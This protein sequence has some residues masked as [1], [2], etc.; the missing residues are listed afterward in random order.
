MFPLVV[1]FS[2]ALGSEPLD[3]GSPELPSSPDIDAR[4][5]A[6]GTVAGPGQ[7]EGVVGII[8]RSSEDSAQIGCSGSLIHPSWVLTAAHC[9]EHDRM[10]QAVL[11]GETLAI[12]W[13]E[14]L[15]DLSWNLSAHDWVDVK[16]VIRHPNYDW[17]AVPLLNDIALLELDSPQTG[18]AL[19]ALNDTNIDNRVGDDLRHVGYGLTGT[20]NQMG[21][22]R[23]KFQ[24]ITQVDPTIVRSASNLQDEGICKGDS[25]GPGLLWVGPGYVATTIISYG[26]EPFGS[27]CFEENEDTRVDA[28]LGWIDG[29]V[30]WYRTAPA[31]PIG[32]GCSVSNAPAPWWLLLFGFAHRRRR[33]R[34]T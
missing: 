26:F 19:V 1:F 21:T 31:T 23:Y 27:G 24:P 16:Q 14:D 13:G 22:K 12:A 5:I 32:C 29:Y 10:A 28:F 20:S 2:L 3:N 6:G 15:S 34:T 4:A 30:P 25:G 11:D 8:L 33:I 17:N 18:R 7:F 9:V